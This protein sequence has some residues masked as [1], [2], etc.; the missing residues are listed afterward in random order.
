[1][2]WSPVKDLDLGVEGL[3]TR[4]SLLQGRTPDLSRPGATVTSQDTYQVRARI[5]RDF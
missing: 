4:V 3:Y 5:Q 2:I 1:L